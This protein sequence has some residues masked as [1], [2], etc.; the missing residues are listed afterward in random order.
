MEI[1]ETLIERY[2]TCGGRVF[3]SPQY[4][5]RWEANAATGGACPDFAVIDESRDPREI[6]VVEV[7]TGYDLGSLFDRIT[8]REKRW[9]ER[10]RKDFGAAVRLLAF[11]R[12]D[13]M[14]EAEAWRAKAGIPRDE[15]CFHPI[16]AATFPWLY[17]TDRVTNGLPR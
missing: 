7:T 11:I 4:D 13:R 5:L 8:H 14:A 15:V 16:E 3:V 1:F 6:V 2:L 17:W 12:A 10:L 9:F